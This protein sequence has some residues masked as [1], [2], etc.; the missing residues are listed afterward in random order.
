M[1]MYDSPNMSDPRYARRYHAGRVVED[2]DAI[3][4]AEIAA[5]C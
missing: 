1:K 3:R 5:G 2:D 4:R